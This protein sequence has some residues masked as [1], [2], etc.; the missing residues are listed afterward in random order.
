MK[1][2]IVIL[3]MLFNSSVFSQTICQWA[4]IPSGQTQTYHTIVKSTVDLS[5]NIIQV[6]R[7]LGIAD[8]NPAPGLSDTLF[9]GSSYNYYVSKT[10][11]A[12]NLIWF[13]NF[14]SQSQLSFFEFIDVRV[15]S[16][17]EIVICGNFYG[18]V[19][20]DLSIAGVDT[21]RSHF[22]TY[23]DY[24]LAK[25]DSLGDYQWAINIGDPIS[26]IKA[27][28]MT[29]LN[30]DRIVV[31]INPNGIVDVDPSNNIH[32][33]IGGNANIV[34]YDTDGNYIWNNHISTLFSYAVLTSS[35]ASNTNGSIYYCSV[36]YYE[37][38]VTKFD[39][40]GNQSWAKTIGEF[41]IGAR[42]N[43]QSILADK[44][45]GEF[46]IVGTYLGAV[47]FDPGATVLLHNS[48]SGFYQDGFIAKYDQN[49][50]PIWVN[51]FPGNVTFGNFSL[52]FDGADIIAAGSMKGTMNFGNGI[53]LNGT[54]VL[55]P[56]YIKYNSNG[57]AQDGFVIPS[58]GNFTSMCKSQN[59]SMII[60]GNISGNTDM[61]PSNGTLILNTP[62]SNFFTAVYQTN[63]P[64]SINEFTNTDIN[65]FP[66]PSNG[67]FSIILPEKNADIIITNILG[68]VVYSANQINGRMNIYL[69]SKGVYLMR[70][71][72]ND[73]YFSRK[74]VIN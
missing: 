28:S 42:V 54:S 49:M 40:L 13:R 16:L 70:I 20:F 5:G 9:S 72:L 37:L 71:K 45:T 12:G 68:Q 22:P 24:F 48:S 25:Y 61:D 66:N 33:T 1:K 19:D 50:N 41:S 29:I 59:Q 34:C 11:I 64:T 65:V 7:I 47:D 58:S 51:V 36:G 56:F 46:Y 21:L 39:V 57:I 53:I 60:S 27:Q 43:P 3:L 8:M 18:L 14:S 38:T 32:N 69:D 31:G 73:Q 17:N 74:I 30:N 44:A 52:D 23:P 63:S 15:N 62:V 35:I 4:Y 10:D 26:T 67:S 2:T 6:G 55:N